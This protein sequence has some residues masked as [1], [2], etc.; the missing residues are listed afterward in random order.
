MQPLLS[1][2]STKI[3]HL[4]LTVIIDYII[5]GVILEAILDISIEV[6]ADRFLYY[7]YAYY[8]LPVV[9][10]SDRGLSVIGGI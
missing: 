7:F 3:D 10:I 6:M 5:K 9:V 4:F 2:R 1:R 8:R